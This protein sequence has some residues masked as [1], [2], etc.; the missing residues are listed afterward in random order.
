MNVELISTGNREI[1][2]R[3]GFEQGESSSQEPKAAMDEGPST[4]VILSMPETA[5]DMPENLWRS[6]TVDRRL[7]SIH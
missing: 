5:V 7:R 3:P 2:I 6:C 4:S 1:R